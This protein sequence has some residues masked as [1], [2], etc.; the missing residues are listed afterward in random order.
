MVGQLRSGGIEGV[1]AAGHKLLQ[2]VASPEPAKRAFAAQVPG[3]VGVRSA[4]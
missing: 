1:L 4:A 2:I 3:E